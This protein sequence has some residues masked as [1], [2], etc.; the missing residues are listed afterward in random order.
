M[1]EINK[2]YCGRCSNT[3]TQNVKISD[4]LFE[5]LLNGEL[6]VNSLCPDCIVELAQEKNVELNWIIRKVKND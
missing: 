5:E 2:Y 3:F 4:E 1:N 6:E